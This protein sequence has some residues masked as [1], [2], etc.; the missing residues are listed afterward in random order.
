MLYHSQSMDGNAFMSRRI[1]DNSILSNPT[2]FEFH[3][4]LQKLKNELEYM[5]NRPHLY[6]EQAKSAL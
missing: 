3:K 1:K 6:N 5:E 4:Q 2:T